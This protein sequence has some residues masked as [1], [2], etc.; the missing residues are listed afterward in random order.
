MCGRMAYTN[1]ASWREIGVDRKA[2]NQYV[3]VIER[4]KGNT[5]DQISVALCVGHRT[6]KGKHDNAR[7]CNVSYCECEYRG[8]NR[9]T[10]YLGACVMLAAFMFACIG[11]IALVTLVLAGNDF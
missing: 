6:E 4:G 10:H 5:N 7:H 3:L 2:A 9:N 1:C 8:A 11:A